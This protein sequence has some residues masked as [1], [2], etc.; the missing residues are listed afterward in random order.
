MSA[1]RICL[2]VN[3]TWNIWNFRRPLVE[4]LLSDG[5][6]VHIL[7]PEDDYVPEIQ[8]LGCQFTP[9][10]MDRKGLNPV[11]E[12]AFLR[13]LRAHLDKIQPD[14]ILGFT[15]KNN[16]FGAMAASKGNLPFIPNVTGLGT[17]FQSSSFLK[18][19][20]IGLYRSAF[21]KCPVVFFQN[22]Q[23]RDL[24][25]KYDMIRDEQV[26]M[27]PGSGIDLERFSPSPDAAERIVSEGPVFLM[28]ARLLREKGVA[29]YAEAAR[30]M[31]KELPTARF[32]VL[33][34][35]GSAYRSAISRA[36]IRG[37]EETHGI[38]YLGTSSDVRSE[39]HEADCIVLPSYYPEGAPR[40]LIEAAAM[41]KPIITTDTPGCRSIVDDATTGYLCAPRDAGD[42]ARA[43]RYFAALPPQARYAMGRA[44]RTKMEREFDVTIVVD[45]YREAIAQCMSAKNRPA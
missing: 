16:V 41:G 23:D 7:A 26:R 13:R 28:V 14:V 39:M 45:A 17:A 10:R 40:S 34:E 2:T 1:T 24:F 32:Q 42:L 30:V 6:E 18:A 38:E 4:A 21:R 31:R 33:G 35:A 27:L 43:M 37:W 44:G 15:I 12:L 19:A 29:E 5:H 3:T 25:L 22:D 9:L 20:S 8:G 36:E 11:A